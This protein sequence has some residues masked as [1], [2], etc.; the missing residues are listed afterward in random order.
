MKSNKNSNLSTS[1]KTDRLRKISQLISASVFII[2]FG[3]LLDMNTAFA[4]KVLTYSDH[5]PLGNMRTTFLNDVFFPAIEKESHGRLKIDAHWGGE[6]AI[7]YNAF[8]AV[9]K[10]DSANIA[11]VV[12]EYK[13]KELPLHQIFKSFIV[14]PTG[15]KQVSFFRTVF[16]EVPEFTAEL[17]NNNIIPIFLSTG[18]RTGFYSREPMGSLRE[19]KDHT[20]RTAS[21]WHTDFLKNVGAKP[22]KIEWGLAVY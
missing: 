13:A 9:Q 6:L 16:D 7:A 12:P 1:M 8:G 2:V 10:G 15:D 22:I 19:L 14:G 17:D 4:Q 5:E 21:F 18:Y 20:W 11:T 3:L